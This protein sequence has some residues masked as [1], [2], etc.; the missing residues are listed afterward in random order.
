M[1]VGS[2]RGGIGCPVSS[3]LPPFNRNSPTSVVWFVGLLSFILELEVA[4]DMALGRQLKQATSQDER[5]GPVEW[6]HALCP[7]VR[8]PDGEGLLKLAPVLVPPIF[9]EAPTDRGSPLGVGDGCL[10]VLGKDHIG[11]EADEG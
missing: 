1:G 6:N 4:D 9:A 3:S 7:T 2:W 5:L 8:Q 11:L 10:A